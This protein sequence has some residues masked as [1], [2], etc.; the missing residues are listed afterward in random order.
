MLLVENPQFIT[1]KNRWTAAIAQL[2]NSTKKQ[3]AQKLLNELISEVQTIDQFHTNLVN[4][5]NPALKTNTKDS[6][7]SIS[8][9]RKQLS[10]LLD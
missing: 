1:E 7:D 8:N 6:R 4:K 2:E 10:K 5:I 9:L 3:T